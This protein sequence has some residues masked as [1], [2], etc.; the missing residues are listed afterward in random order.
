MNN[1]HVF[2][3]IG[4]QC[5]TKTDIILKN[6][7]SNYQ[8]FKAEHV[9]AYVPYL[10]RHSGSKQYEVGIAQ[11]KAGDTY[12]LVREKIINSSSDGNAIDINDGE[13]YIFANEY[14]FNT[15]FPS[16]RS[17]VLVHLAQ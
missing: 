1:V 9:N 14:N 2:E 3:N 13:F 7:L 12:Y 6:V 5:N 16:T 8:G 10:I 4:Y 15:G 17:D 11:L